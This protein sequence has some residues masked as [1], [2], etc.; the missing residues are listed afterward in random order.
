M[1]SLQLCAPFRSFSADTIVMLRHIVVFWTTLRSNSTDSSA[2]IWQNF[3]DEI[4]LEIS[5]AKYFVYLILSAFKYLGH[6]WN[7]PSTE[8]FCV[9][10]I[11]LK[12]LKSNG[13]TQKSAMFCFVIKKAV[14]KRVNHHES[15]T[16]PNEW[17]KLIWIWKTIVKSQRAWKC[18]WCYCAADRQ[19]SNM[20][21][22]YSNTN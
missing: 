3:F 19:V 15:K 18:S 17:R 10:W 9:A 14:I 11:H 5:C 16:Q 4:L 8:E 7:Y 1:K 20:I 6:P 13:L 12:C 21:I 2:N 22:T